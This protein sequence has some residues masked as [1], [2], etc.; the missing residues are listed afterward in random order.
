MDAAPFG[1]KAPA[2]PIPSRRLQHLIECSMEG[3]RRP[4]AF[5]L[6]CFPISGLAR[7]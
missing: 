2:S 4:C 3:A 5:R 1:D 6:P 7:K